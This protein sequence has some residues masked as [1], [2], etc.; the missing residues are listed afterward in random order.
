M[1][2]ARVLEQDAE[3][4][5]GRNPLAAAAPARSRDSCSRFQGAHAPIDWEKSRLS[6]RAS[7]FRFGAISS[8]HKSAPLLRSPALDRHQLI[9]ASSACLGG[10]V[11]HGRR[12]P[13]ENAFDDHLGDIID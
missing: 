2:R 9:A 11:N 3:P 5:G 8:I 6:A 13:S 4:R 7:S 12:H 10:L 1:Y